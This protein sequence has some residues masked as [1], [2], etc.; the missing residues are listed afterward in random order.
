MTRDRVK[1]LLP[2]IEAF[3]A[4]KVVQVRVEQRWHDAYDLEFTES[5]DDYRIKPEP[6]LRPWKVEEVPVGAL[7]RTKIKPEHRYLIT[8]VCSVGVSLG[9]F[10][11]ANYQEVELLSNFEHSIDGGKTWKECGVYE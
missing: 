7:V 5:A 8:S 10:E 11:G 3:A 9:R 4:G 1:E 6:K 2:V